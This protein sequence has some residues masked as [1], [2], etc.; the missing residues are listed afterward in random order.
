MFQL[1][2]SL[3]DGIT[4]YLGLC[5][6]LEYLEILIEEFYEILFALRRIGLGIEY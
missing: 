1:L 5:A 2:I 6:G 3:T 4:K